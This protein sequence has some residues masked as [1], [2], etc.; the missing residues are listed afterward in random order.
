[1]KKCKSK[2]YYYIIGLFVISFL[3]SCGR[4]KTRR[5]PIANSDVCEEFSLAL[6]NEFMEGETKGVQY[7]IKRDNGEVRLVLSNDDSQV[8]EIMNYNESDVAYV[9]GIISSAMGRQPDYI[10]VHDNEIIFWEDAYGEQIIYSLDGSE[11]ENKISP[12]NEDLYFVQYDEH[13]YAYQLR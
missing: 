4:E 13:W 1:M 3:C 12:N 2:S 6:Y 9:L 8:K 10:Y 11:P 5:D 7:V